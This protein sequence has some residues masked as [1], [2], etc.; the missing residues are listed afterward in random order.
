M[1]PALVNLICPRCNAPHSEMTFIPFKIPMSFGLIVRTHWALCPATGEPIIRNIGD[2][3][4]RP[5]HCCYVHPNGH[6]CGQPA[7]FVA[8]W[9]HTESDFSDGCGAH[10]YALVSGD[11]DEE[12]VYI[13]AIES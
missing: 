5:R 11:A 4:E 1:K 7:Q 12:R 3:S 10:I 2:V 8:T 6:P 13:S 9:G